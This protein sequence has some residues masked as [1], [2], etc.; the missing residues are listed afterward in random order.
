MLCESI[1]ILE[2]CAGGDCAAT[3]GQESNTAVEQ[4]RM[5]V[6]N[7]CLEAMAVSLSLLLIL[8]RPDPS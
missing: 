6:P 1:L 4:R 5:A 7:L 3:G 8:F 2:E